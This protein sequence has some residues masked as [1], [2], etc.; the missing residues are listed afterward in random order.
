[1]LALNC[2]A[3]TEDESVQVLSREKASRVGYWIHNLELKVVRP[4]APAADLS[5][6]KVAR[7]L[8]VRAGTAYAAA[9]PRVKTVLSR[10]S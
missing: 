1:M 10:N 4:A 3:P 8:G 9:P 2:E 7:A 6:P 5:W